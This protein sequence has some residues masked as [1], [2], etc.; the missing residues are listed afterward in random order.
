MS[1]RP[2]VPLTQDAFDRLSEKLAY[3]EGEART[4]VIDEIATARA[5]GDLSENAEYHA[6]KDKQGLQEAEVR[7]LR[8]MVDNA[9][10]IQSEDDGIV[11]PGMLVTIRHEGEEPETYLLGQR[12]EKSAGHDILTPE[13]PIGLAVLGR[14]AGDLVAAKIPGGRELKVEIVAVAVP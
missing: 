11:R 10:I 5:H 2:K 14:S 3:L 12:E 7:R 9:E 6:A 4:Q 13:S 8:E 1:D